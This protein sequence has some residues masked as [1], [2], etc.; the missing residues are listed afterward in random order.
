MTRSPHKNRAD[1]LATEARHVARFLDL[2][3]LDAEVI[4][5]DRPDCVLVINGC[6]IGLE[7]Q[8]LTE[9]DLASNQPNLDWLAKAL[10]AELGRRGVDPELDVGVSVNAAAPLFRKRRFVEELIPRIADLVAERAPTVTTEETLEVLGPELANVGIVGPS[11]VYVS[12]IAGFN[13]P[14]AFV[15]PSAWG[16]VDSSVRRAIREKEKRLDA[17]VANPPLAELWLLLVTGETWQQATDSVLTQWTRVPTK[18]HRVYLMDLR[19]GAL[20]RV[21]DRVLAP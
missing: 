3:H 9:E 12:R 20:Q 17:Y 5:G 13:G 11:A 8:E 18:F 19:T 15:Q 4:P 6:R 10:T 1:Q 2:E 16:P 14:L 7:H 21:D